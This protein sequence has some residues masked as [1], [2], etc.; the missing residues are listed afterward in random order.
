MSKKPQTIAQ[1]FKQFPDDESC[2]NHLF[3]I[4]FGQGFECPSCERPSNWYRIKAERAYSCQWCGHH[5]HP[6]V[7]TPFEQTRTPLQLWFYAIYLFTTTRNGVAAKELERQLGVTYKT[8]WRMAHL[9]REHM[10]DVDGE[11]PLGGVFKTVEVDE[12][13]IGGEATGKGTG[14]KANKT[15]IMA[16]VERGGSVMTKVI[17]NRRKSTLQSEIVANVKPHTEIHTDEFVSYAGLDGT[18]HGFW[19]KTVNHSSGEY[20]RGHVTTNGVE[21]F[22]SQLKRSI[23]GTHIHVSGKHLWKYAKEAEYRFNRRDCPETMLSELLS[24]FG[25]LPE[26]RD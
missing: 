10:A 25:P 15:A 4:R 11:E 18:G 12:T 1:F 21:G 7:G 19:H 16:M 24:T 2:L 17:P 20:V 26:R 9:I 14:Y 23:H 22:W 6:T 3:E 13:Y 5:L 8:A